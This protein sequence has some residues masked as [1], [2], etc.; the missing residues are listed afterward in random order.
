MPTAHFEVIYD[1]AVGSEVQDFNGHRRRLTLPSSV[2]WLAAVALIGCML[3][4]ANSLANDSEAELGIGGLVL[5]KNAHVEMRSENLYVS[6]E[7]I[8]V[9]YRFYNKSGSD[10]R[11]VVAFPLPQVNLDDGND[12]ERNGLTEYEFSTRVD[13]IPVNTQI[14]RRATVGGRDRTDVLKP[15]EIPLDPN[16]S[17][18][19]LDR[20][21]RDAWDKLTRAGVVKTIQYKGTPAEKHLRPLWALKTAYYWE[22]TFPAKKEIT[23]EHRYVPS[24]GGSVPMDW[25]R[26]WS[27]SEYQKK[28]CVDREFV[29]SAKQHKN[30]SQRWISYILT[31]GG[32]WA[33]PIGDFRLVVD[34]GDPSNLVSFCADGVKKISATEFEVR[35]KN[36]VPSKDLNVLILSPLPRLN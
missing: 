4:P 25:S 27:V 14:E 19:A 35:K 1:T 6:T 5:R 17:Q 36:F 32:N 30:S 29:L 23:I 12:D 15:Y 18:D 7:E 33:G 26:D 31:T 3:A 24:V 8:R 20:L 22:Q 28:F 2:S 9:Q 10:V 21:P 34:K 16:A 11:V 13:G